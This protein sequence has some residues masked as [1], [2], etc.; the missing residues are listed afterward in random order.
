MSALRH[1]ERKLVRDE[2]SS[3][4]GR[5]VAGWPTRRA[6]GTPFVVVLGPWSV[7]GIFG[8]PTSVTGCGLR[9]ALIEQT[10]PSA[11]RDRVEYVDS[12]KS[13]IGVAFFSMQNQANLA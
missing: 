9:K 6:A 13:E 8:P 3:I 11:T 10:P 1:R 12:C 4:A 5:P 2:F 7:A